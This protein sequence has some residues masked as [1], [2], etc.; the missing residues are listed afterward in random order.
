MKI[1]YK[2]GDLITAGLSREVNVVAHQCNCFNT[3]GSG[4]A[5]LMAKA[6][7]GLRDADNNT[8]RGD[9]TK[10]G[11]VSVSY[12]MDGLLAFNLYGQYSYGRGQ[13]T[14]Y[15]AVEDSLAL[16]YK[17][18]INNQ[19]ITNDLHVGLPRIGCGL[20]GGDWSIVSKI[21][22]EQLCQKGIPVTVYVLNESD[23]PEE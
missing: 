17:I 1:Q 18:I 16:M 3:M 22:E 2:V 20:A 12:E 8:L 13:H 5:P 11:K 15:K 23:I 4:I 7:V 21:I 14:D 6:F 9:Y 19:H 10:L